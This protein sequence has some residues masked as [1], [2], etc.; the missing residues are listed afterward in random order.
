MQL[1]D[2]RE[3]WV[4]MRKSLGEKRKAIS[5]DQI[6]E[7]TRLYG[8]FQENDRVRI[9]SNEAL[10]YLR[11][12]VEQPL[13]LRW[14]ITDETLTAVRSSARLV[15]LPPGALDQLLNRL[16]EHRG[17]TFTDRTQLE[18]KL[19]QVLA[20]SGLSRVQ[21]Q[22]VR[23]ALAIRDADAPVITNRRGEPEPDP[24]LRDQ[25]NVPL[26]KL[27]VRFEPDPGARLATVH[28]RAGVEDYV[29]T[30]VRPYAP[31][32]WVDHTKTRIG[33]EIPLTRHFYR[34]V[35]PRSLEEIDAEI[36]ALE[37]E[38]QALLREVAE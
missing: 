33:Y 25:E 28:Y 15:A 37:A 14:E 26:P 27:P 5:P 12:T 8:A 29:D 34:Y 31:E 19:D 22:A 4:K 32:A 1:V 2:A 21:E 9:L 36:K 16:A 18:I 17:L 7:I 23:D 10:G 20:A 13:R 35:P 6:A 30:E 24:D 3:L 11:I 38:I